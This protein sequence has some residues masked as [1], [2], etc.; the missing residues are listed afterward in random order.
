[1]VWHKKFGPAKNILRPVK[2]QGI[3]AGGKSGGALPDPKLFGPDQN[4]FGPDPKLFWTHGRT[5]HEFILL[6]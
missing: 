6:L 1:M 3:S 4:Y 2:G 5:G